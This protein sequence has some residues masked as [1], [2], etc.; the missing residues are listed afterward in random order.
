MRRQEASVL[1]YLESNDV[2]RASEITAAAVRFHVAA[3]HL[4][5][6]A[7]TQRGTRLFTREAV[8]EFRRLYGRR[9]QRRGA[10]RGA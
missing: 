2:G 3:G 5:P 10:T 6:A 9:R 1:V 7:V 4:H 8:E